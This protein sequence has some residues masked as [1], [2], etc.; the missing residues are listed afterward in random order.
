M[1]PTANVYNRIPLNCSD[2]NLVVVVWLTGQLGQHG[3]LPQKT[4][5]STCSDENSA[6]IYKTQDIAII[7]TKQGW[8][9]STPF[10]I[11]FR[12]PVQ[13]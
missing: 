5:E 3:C 10:G 8:V 13:F 6:M 4:V 9:S 2:Y 1:D 7:I 12:L 11:P